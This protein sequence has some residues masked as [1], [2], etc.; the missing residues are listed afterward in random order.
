MKELASGRPK[1]SPVLMDSMLNW[2][3][4]QQAQDETS[5]KGTRYPSSISRIRKKKNK[6]SAKLLGAAGAGKERNT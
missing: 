4:L 2:T 3:C 6:F 5:E 1:P